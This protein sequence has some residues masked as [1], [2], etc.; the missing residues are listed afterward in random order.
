MQY[1]E[2]AYSTIRNVYTIIENYYLQLNL[3][4]YIFA[5]RKDIKLQN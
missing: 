2:Q 1:R 4:W 5:I 3:L